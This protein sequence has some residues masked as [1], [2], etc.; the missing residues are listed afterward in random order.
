M[1]RSPSNRRG[2]KGPQGARTPAAASLFARRTQPSS[3]QGSSD[4]RTVTPSGAFPDGAI[5]KRPRTRPRQ[6]TIYEEARVRFGQWARVAL[7]D[8]HAD[9][10]ERLGFPLVGT[11][12]ARGERLRFV[13]RT[14]EH[15]RGPPLSLA[16]TGG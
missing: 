3:A 11:V 10:L 1:K 7:S 5:T 9:L 12:G 4:S 16:E 13:Y 14:P 6:L 2:P 8:F 15:L